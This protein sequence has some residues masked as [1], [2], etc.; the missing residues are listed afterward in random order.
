MFTFPVDVQ[1][2]L[3]DTLHWCL[4]GLLFEI[5]C[6]PALGLPVSCMG[7]LL[8]HPGLCVGDAL[9]LFL[10]AALLC[11]PC[12]RLLM[13]GPNMMSSFL[14][15]YTLLS[16]VCYRLTT[17]PGSLVPRR[18]LHWEVVYIT[19]RLRRRRW[20]A[21]AVIINPHLLSATWRVNL[22]LSLRIPLGAMGLLG[23]KSSPTRHVRWSPPWTFPGE[24]L[25][26]LSTGLVSVLQLALACLQ[27]ESI[28][29][30]LLAP[31]GPTTHVTVLPGLLRPDPMGSLSLI[32]VTSICFLGSCAR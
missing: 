13:M 30:L 26:L 18:S 1:T 8:M 11:T 32:I 16:I 5:P 7:V 9:L 15:W 6:V 10:V 22:I 3:T 20:L 17:L 31:V 28:S 4:N 19:T 14:W 2:L 21:R 24:P 25:P 12:A 27:P 29:S 23:S